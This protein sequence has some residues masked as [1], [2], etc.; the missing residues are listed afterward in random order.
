MFA[1]VRIGNKQ[2]K[3]SEKSV[4]T[5]DKID[6]K[7]GDKVEFTDVLLVQDG[8]KVQVGKP[9]VSGAKV[10][11]TIIAQEK[12]EKIDIHRFKSKVRYRRARGFRAQ[13]TRLE[14]TAVA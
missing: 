4:I 9:T 10:T 7:A 13:L 3:V 14:V 11:A 8:K 1:I 12:G 2:Y 6:G 5:V